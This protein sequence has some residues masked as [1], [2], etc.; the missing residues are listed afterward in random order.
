[1]VSAERSRFTR[2]GRSKLRVVVDC[3]SKRHHRC[4]GNDGSALARP[5]IKWSLNVAITLSAAFFMEVWRNELEWHTSGVEMFFKFF[6]T[7]IVQH[8]DLRYES[9]FS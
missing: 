2:D 1:M 3:G 4:I 6:R 8:L 5:E 9:S 7:F